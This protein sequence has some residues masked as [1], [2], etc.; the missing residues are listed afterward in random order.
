MYRKLFNVMC[1][2]IILFAVTAAWCEMALSVSA[3]KS[4]YLIGEPLY[5]VLA[6]KNTGTANDKLIAFFM[7]DANLVGF[8]IATPDGKMH[9][10][11]SPGQIDLSN[12]GWEAAVVSLAPGNKRTA[13]IDLT[14]ENSLDQCL[15]A[16]RG[17]YRLR[18]T[19]SIKSNWPAP[20]CSL[21]SNELILKVNEPIGVDKS[22][23]QLLLNSQ[24]TA[25]HGLWNCFPAQESCYR[26][27]IKRYPKSGY[28][29]YAKF[30]LA[31]VVGLK[32][33]MSLRGTQG[34]RAAVV[35]AAS[36][37]DEVYQSA[38]ET[39]FG[40]LAKR[41]AARAYARLGNSSKAKELL[42]SASGSAASTDEDSLEC[43]S[44]MDAVEKGRFQRESGV[45]EEA[46]KD[47]GA[48]ADSASINRL[49]SVIVSKDASP[50]QKAEAST[51]LVQ[52]GDCAVPALLGVLSSPD[53]ADSRFYAILALGRLK[54]PDAVEPLCRLLGDRSYGPRRYAAIAL[55]EIGSVKAVD[56]LE[57][58]MTD[59]SYV[60]DDAV[61]ALIR[62]DSPKARKLLESYYFSKSDPRFKLSISCVPQ[63]VGMS[64]TV[65]IRATVTNLSQQDVV[66]RL[67]NG[68]PLCTIVIRRNDG[69]FVISSI[70]IYDKKP[71]GRVENHTLNSGDTYSWTIAGKTERLEAA[72]HTFD[73]TPDIT[74]KGITSNTLLLGNKIFL[75]LPPGKLRIRMIADLA[76][77]ENGEASS[78]KGESGTKVVSGEASLSTH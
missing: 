72:A 28:A 53:V 52:S 26:Q 36:L 12:E 50:A 48:A 15:L 67:Y 34:A 19:Y 55:G 78:A 64:D 3:S 61:D 31:K 6:I 4:A 11:K 17:E 10:Y 14:F 25:E 18:A 62:I 8:E 63:A 38:G 54:S 66:L 46:A 76:P 7:P 75:P 32:A 49:V 74:P 71:I 30:Y 37:F 77:S 58:A 65:E 9:V 23:Y 16:Q 44:F 5:V 60:R 45:P 51:S 13:S 59:I 70:G 20:A 24:I 1:I 29:L 21:K 40:L 27:L 41:Y 47:A 43:A 68:A 39:S 42:Q 33:L 35:E 57:Q 2:L 73:I 22:A 56:A 69:A